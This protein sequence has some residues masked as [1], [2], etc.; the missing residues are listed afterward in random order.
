VKRDHQL[1]S[2]EMAAE[3]ELVAGFG[4]EPIEDLGASR[5]TRSMALSA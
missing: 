1:L 3:T 5:D 4:R 2:R